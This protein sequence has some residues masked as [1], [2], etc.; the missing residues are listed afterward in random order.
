MERLIFIDLIDRVVIIPQEMEWWKGSRYYRV[1]G[2]I[3]RAM[4]RCLFLALLV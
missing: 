1:V 2:G 4:I 3:S